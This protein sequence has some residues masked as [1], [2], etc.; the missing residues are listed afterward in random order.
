MHSVINVT[1][2]MACDKCD[3]RNGR[4]P[5]ALH[6]VSCFSSKT[7][8]QFLSYLTKMESDTLVRENIMLPKWHEHHTFDDDRYLMT[9][10]KIKGTIYSEITQLTKNKRFTKG[11]FYDLNVSDKE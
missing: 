8:L 5:A 3:K 4:L 6:K 2:K 10:N 1:R 9:N 7:S 11:S